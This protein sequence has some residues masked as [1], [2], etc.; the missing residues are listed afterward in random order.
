MSNLIDDYIEL[1]EGTEV[2]AMFNVWA[3]YVLISACISRRV[4]YL[5]GTMPIYCN[6]Y[7]ILVGDAGNGKSMAI[8]Q[9]KELLLDIDGIPL[10]SQ[11]ETPQ[12]LIRRLAGDPQQNP[13]VT[14]DHAF[15]TRGPG[16]DDVEVSPVTILASEFINFIGKDQEAWINI[17]NDVY[18]S[19]RVFEYH[20]KNQGHDLINGPYFVL[21]GALPTETSFDLQ[22]NHIIQ[23]GFAR[24]TIFQYG[25]RRFDEP[26]AFPPGG[27]TKRDLRDRVIMQCRALQQ[28]QG[29]MIIPQETREFYKTWYD[30]H[31]RNVCRSAPPH[32][33]SWVNSKSIQVLKIA[34]LTSLAEGHSLKILPHH[35]QQALDFFAILEKDLYGVFGGAGRNELAG[36]AVKMATWLKVQEYAVSRKTLEERFFNECKPPNEFGTCLEHLISRGEA[37]ITNVNGISYIGTRAVIDRLV[38]QVAQPHSPQPV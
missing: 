6:I 19:G 34:M 7:V 28:L 15:I 33:R 22:K 13:P 3:A 2:P 12:G 9:V 32:S 20:T 16:G 18:D 5:H 14:Y 26:C 11:M 31:S 36:V 30:D 25:E 4:W 38:N 1:H 37:A 17:L 29:G 24:R 27:D 8:H 23:S 35:I 21:Y 10:S